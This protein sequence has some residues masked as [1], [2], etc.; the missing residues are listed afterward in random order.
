MI[1]EVNVDEIPGNNPSS[2]GRNI[3]REMF[4]DRMDLVLTD[5]GK[6]PTNSTRIPVSIRDCKF[7]KSKFEHKK[8]H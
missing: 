4:D 7:I 5:N 6:Q 3:F 8:D 2:F 1:D